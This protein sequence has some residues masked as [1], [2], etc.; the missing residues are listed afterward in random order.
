LLGEAARASPVLAA[1]RLRAGIGRF[2]AFVGFRAGWLLAFA[3]VT[4]L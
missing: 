2:S 4:I 3:I 1:V